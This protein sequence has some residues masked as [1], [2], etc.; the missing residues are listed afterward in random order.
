MMFHGEPFA[1]ENYCEAIE[2]VVQTSMNS[3]DPAVIGYA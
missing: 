2:A 3:C 1:E